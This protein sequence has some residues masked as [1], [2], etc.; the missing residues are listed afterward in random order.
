M[1]RVVVTGMGVVTPLGNTLDKLWDGIQ[2]G[3]SATNLM[4][5]DLFRNYTG[6]EVKD[7]LRDWQ[8]YFGVNIV[9]VSRAT[10]FAMS[11]LIEALENAGIPV[12]DIDPYKTGV[13]LGG[14]LSFTNDTKVY[15][16]LYDEIFIRKTNSKQVNREELENYT[17]GYHASALIA[18]VL[19]V[20][21]L[22][23]TVS[24]AC[25][26]GV[27]S[28]C[29]GY[30][31]I[32]KGELKTAIVGGSDASLNLE[33]FSLF[34][35]LDVL[36]KDGNPKEACRPFSKNRTGCV[37]GEGAGILVIESLESAQERNANIL[38]EIVGYAAN[39]DTYHITS[40]D[41]TGESCAKTIK[42]AV[43][44]AK[45][46]LK[47]VDYI[48]AHGTGTYYNDLVETQGIKQAFGEYSKEIPISSNKSMLGHLLTAAGAVEL[49]IT[50]LSM[51]DSIIPPTVHLDLKDEEC[52][53]D[54]VSGG[55]RES[56]IEYAL[57]NSFGFGGQNVGI[58]VKSWG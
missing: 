54:Y 25:T 20:R 48:N 23:K 28:I 27:Y 46:E 31:L 10:A 18:S 22:A 9:H 44:N 53:L 40:P 11:A 57:S 33:G 17:C 58:V 37:L 56:N 8:E 19:G 1:H 29:E 39:T 12:K 13:I 24:N 4:E 41:Q 34:T 14:G 3:I 26:S 43:D 49:I 55:A 42:A 52:D 38:A 7:P 36:V 15:S 2:K 16:Y 21:K 32:R 35:V 50:I 51:R 5:D 30:E 47:Q 6:A 45:I